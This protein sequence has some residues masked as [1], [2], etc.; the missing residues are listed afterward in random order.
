MVLQQLLQQ[1]PVLIPVGYEGHA[2]TFLKWGEWWVKCDRREDQRLYDHVV[3]YRIKQPDNVT[4]EMLASLIYV[5]QSDQFINEALDERLGLVPVTEL[6]VEAQISG[7]CSWA[8]VEAAIPALFYL[9]LAM[10][11]PQETNTTYFK[12]LALQFF[13]RFRD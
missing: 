3:F 12:T 11:N 13:H 5:K 4:A 1:E 9:I 7:N 10:N 2:I 8:N 6:K